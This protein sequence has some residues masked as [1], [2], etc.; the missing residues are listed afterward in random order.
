MQLNW[1]TS[2]W[3]G[4]QLGG[5]VWILVAAAIALGHDVWTGLILL[6]IFLVP[7]MAGYLLWQQKKFS[8]HA[9]IQI[10]FSLSGIFGLLAIY[11]LDRNDLWLEIQKGGSI[12]VGLAYLLLILIV[13]ILMVTFYIKFGCEENAS[14]T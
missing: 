4:S 8:C 2:G 11:I 3:F 13:L 10:L 1:N 6:V 9:S 12:S 5:T 7:N 14:S